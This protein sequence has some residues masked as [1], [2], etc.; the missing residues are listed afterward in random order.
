MQPGDVR[1]LDYGELPR[2]GMF[3]CLEVTFPLGHHHPRR[4]FL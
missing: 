2:F 1:Y 3:D 4:G